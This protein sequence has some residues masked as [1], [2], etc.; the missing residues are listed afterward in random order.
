VLVENTLSRHNEQ[1]ATRNNGFEGL[2]AQLTFNTRLAIRH[3]SLLTS[4]IKSEIFTYAGRGE[5]GE[6]L[7]AKGDCAMLTG[8]SA[9][10][11]DI[12]RNAGFHFA[13]KTM[14]GYDDLGAMDQN[15]T[16]GG[17]SL[18][19]MAGKSAKEN[20]GVAKFFE[21][22]ARPETQA[23]WHQATGYLPLNSA[24]YEITRSKGYY[25]RYPGTDVPVRE[26]ASKGVPP[27]FSRGVRLGNMPQVRAILDEE[28]ESVFAQRKAPKQGLD[29]A[30][31][32]GNELL[33][34]FERNH[35]M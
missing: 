33:R 31:T 12:Q 3:I 2:D 17:A 19:A 16:M 35:P 7:F 5:D 4:W 24:A 25:D 27:A 8:S 32:R 20:R 34:R 21:F 11:A 29:D 14:P 15:S 13:V 28:L 22:L 23:A 10:Y 1:F 9:S 6:K 26:I 30:V 18:W